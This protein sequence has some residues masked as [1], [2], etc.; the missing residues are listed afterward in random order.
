MKIKPTLINQDTE[1]EEISNEEQAEKHVFLDLMVDKGQE[2]LRIDKFLQTKVAGLTRSKV[3][4]AIDDGLV[5]IN[6]AIVKANYKVRPGDRM[7][8]YTFREP[9]ST[10]IIPEDIPLDIVYEDDD[11]MVINKPFNMVVH[12]GHG[13]YTGTVVNALSFYLQKEDEAAQLPRIGLV[14][15][16][17]K[18][19]TG[20][21]VIG[22]TEKAMNHLSEQFKD[23]TVNRRYVALVWGDVSEDEGTIDTYIGRH[24]R[25]RKIFDVYQPDE[26]T[27]KH[28]IT[29]YKVIER[30]NYV[31]LVECRLETGRTHQ[32]RVHMKHIGHT[33]FNDKTYGGDRILKGTVYSKYKQF[34]ENCFALLPRQ[35]L[36]AK[37]LGFIHPITGKEMYFESELPS[38]MKQ[39]IEKW[40]V[41]AKAR[42][43]TE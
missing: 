38:D 40:Q 16:I 8:A 14:H 43:L 18:D 9:E 17:D 41:F 39:V 33:L 35:A 27:G 15:R 26:E 28:A 25:L 24:Q 1:D 21:L 3:Q 4:Q 42:K 11:L 36:H 22:K 7:V 19:T 20:L 6:D 2:P 34:V 37:T 30:L 13:N 23:H 10:E 31:T 29:H 5:L 12:P 32:I